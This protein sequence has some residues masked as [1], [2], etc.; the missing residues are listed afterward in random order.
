SSRS[1][2]SGTT[3]TVVPPGSAQAGSMNKMLFPAPVGITATSG[4]IPALIALTAS[5]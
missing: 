5:S 4:L 2:I 3:T 1:A